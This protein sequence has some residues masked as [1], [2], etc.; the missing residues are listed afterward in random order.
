M[1][2]RLYPSDTPDAEWLLLEPLLPDAHG[3][4]T[5][6]HHRRD[7]VDAITYL[8]GNGRKRRALP[9]DFPP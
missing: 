5:G 1:R 4:P 8:V 6:K 3:W 9:A 2:P 7:V